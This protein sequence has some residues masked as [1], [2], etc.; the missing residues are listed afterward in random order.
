MN[1]KDLA[2]CATAMQELYADLRA[3]TIELKTA[4]ELANISGKYLK[5]FQLDLAERIFLSGEAKN[6]GVN[7]L[8]RT[9]GDALPGNAVE[10]SH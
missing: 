7:V 4:S 6:A 8:T 3:G 9:E 10:V 5:A 1:N 2:A